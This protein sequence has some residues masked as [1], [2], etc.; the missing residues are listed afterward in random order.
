MP[1]RD[2]HSH[3]PVP[4][5]QQIE[6][7]VRLRAAQD[8]VALNDQTQDANQPLGTRRY[9]TRQEFASS[10][11]ASA[12]DIAKIEAFAK[13][14]NLVVVTT[15]P[16]Q[17][18]VVLAGRAAAFSNAFGATLKEYE[19]P[20]GTYRGRV[21]HLTAPRDVADLT[22]GVFGL[23]DRPQATPKFQIRNTTGW[24]EAHA[25]GDSFRRRNWRNFITSRK[26]WTAVGNALA[27]LNLVEEVAL[28]ILMPI[29]RK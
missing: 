21:G 13:Q 14:H 22:E 24:A 20:N 11:G 5:D 27:L 3:G 25:A 17:R 2:A 29:L 15:N 18:N 19:H 16:A 28:L 1:L 26:D 8:R 12:N 9:M 6:V 7:T 4:A 23:D 10:H